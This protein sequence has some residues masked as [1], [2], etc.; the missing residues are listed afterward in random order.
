MRSLTEFV[1]ML[2]GMKMT[3]PTFYNYLGVTMDKSLSYKE[4]IEKVLK[5][6]NSRVKILSYIGQ[7]LTL[8]AAEKYTNYDAVSSTLLQQR[9]C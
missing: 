4:H 3:V 9:F 7:D 1:A 6:E 5:K 2:Q 8:H